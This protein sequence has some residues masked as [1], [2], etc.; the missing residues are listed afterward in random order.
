MWR[1]LEDLTW[2]DRLMLRTAVSC[3]MYKLLRLVDSTPATVDALSIPS[4]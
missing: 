2:L 3:V 4:N 1:N